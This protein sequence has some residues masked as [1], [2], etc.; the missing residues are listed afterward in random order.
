MVSYEAPVCGRAECSRLESERQVKK[1]ESMNKIE[2]WWRISNV[3]RS[4]FYMAPNRQCFG[5]KVC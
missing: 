1:L 3:H 4:D 5:E 2:L